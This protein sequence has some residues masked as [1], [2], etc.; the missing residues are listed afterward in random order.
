MTLPTLHLPPAL[1]AAVDA[2][3][4]AWRAQE[5]TR[6]LWERDATLWTGGDEARWLGWLDVAAAERA[7]VPRLQLFA[8]EIA[9]DGITDVAVLGMGGSSLCPFV[10][11]RTFGEM[12][13]RPRLHV[14]DSTDPSQIL[15]FASRLD[16]ARTLFVVSSKSGSTL[17][18]NIL[19]D[20]FLQQARA[21]LGADAATRHFIAIT[22]P[23][24]QLE[25][26]A[27]A[28]G[29]RAIFA[30]VPGIG[31]RFSALSHFG[32]VPG[33]LTGV[34]ADTL[35]AGAETMMAAS[36]EED[37][38]KNP[39]VLLGIVMGEAA[40][41]GMDKLTLIAAP[42]IS[43]IGAWLEQLIA[44]STGKIG[45]GIIPV[46]G[47]TVYPPEAYGDD[48]L[49][50]HLHLGE[51]RDPQDAGVKALA[52]AGRPVIEIM[53]PD[54]L[55][56]GGEFFRWE[57][58]TAVAGAV[59]QLNP[60]DQPDVEA[61][62]IATRKLMD[63]VEKA[64]T[65]PPEKPFHDEGGIKLFADQA[66]TQD[67]QKLASERTSGGYLRAHLNR[68][69]RGDYAA[70]LAYVEMGEENLPPLL[71]L[72]QHVSGGGRIAT[73]LGFG[74]R[75]LHSTGQ[76]HKGGPGTGVFLQVTCE[77]ARDLLVPG[78]SYSFG[79]V[80]AAQARGDLAVLAERGRRAM[81]VHLGAGVAAGL[82]QLDEMVTRA[83]A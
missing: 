80:I 35:L 9:R 41:L 48:R 40:M 6:R 38:A 62:K 55:S 78:R 53:V 10:F 68:H 51:G 47:E 43:E 72:R 36:R 12:K 56:L 42:G 60:F 64:G 52:A 34:D 83:L 39:A 33:A 16:L 63:E 7:S 37:P 58:A 82:R 65:L 15:T 70:I 74:P 45:K 32:L 54:T 21:S 28:D 19:R 29:F 81:R 20:Y 57:L 25:R 75:F 13:G 26:Q 31:G 23:G 50:V 3:V 79:T 22:D 18:P 66:N 61:S 44:E 71:S 4:V 2:R 27:K 8:D 73:T 76:L 17:E 59:M 14:L 77:E 69:R 46:P 5:G 11:A 30:G 67:I 1:R 49:F 24:S